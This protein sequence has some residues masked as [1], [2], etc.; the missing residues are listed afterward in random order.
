METKCRYKEKIG[1]KKLGIPTAFDE[2]S[3]ESAKVE[4]CNNN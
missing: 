3:N 2:I 1:H 4:T